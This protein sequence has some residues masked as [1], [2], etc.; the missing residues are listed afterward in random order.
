M[1]DPVFRKK[2]LERATSPEA[3]NDYIKVTSPGI[4]II[5]AAVLFMLIGLIVWGAV[6]KLE[7]KISAVAVSNGGNIICYVRE[8][9]I[10]SVEKGDVVR[11]GGAEYAVESISKE[12]VKAETDN[13]LSEYALR[14]GELSAGEWVYL[15]QFAGEMP[16]GVYGADIVTGQVS[17]ITFLFN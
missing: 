4:W 12:P 13:N 16:E 17:P 11:I 10:E 3:L 9:D 5:L 8:S 6:G 2:S 1:E 15:V 14:V 7:T